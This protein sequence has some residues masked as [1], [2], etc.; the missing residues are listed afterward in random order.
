METQLSKRTD[1]KRGDMLLR[2]DFVEQR[3]EFQ[4]RQ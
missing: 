4:S 3:R 2:A 1:R